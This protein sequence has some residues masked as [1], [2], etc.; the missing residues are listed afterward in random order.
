MKPTNPMQQLAQWKQNH[1]KAKAEAIKQE[2]SQP[3]QA[4]TN[5]QKFAK[6]GTSQPPKQA[7]K[8]TKQGEPNP[9]QKAK[10]SDFLVLPQISRSFQLCKD[11]VNRCKS[12]FPDHFHH[13]LQHAQECQQLA[14]AF[15]QGLALLQKIGKNQPLADDDKLHLK[16]FKQSV[17]YLARHFNDLQQHIKAVQD[18]DGSVPTE[19]A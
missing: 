18:G 10:Q 17:K 12:E 19:T 1:A 13:K 4:V 6:N 3:K 11:S 16:N 15:N 8:A 5:A 9:V 2:A 7:V 14:V